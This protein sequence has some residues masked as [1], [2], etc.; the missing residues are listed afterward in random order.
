[1]PHT[2]LTFLPFHSFL[3]N[4]FGSL[5]GFVFNNVCLCFLCSNSFLCFLFRYIF[6]DRSFWFIFGLDRF[7]LF[8]SCMYTTFSFSLR[9]IFLGRNL[10]SFRLFDNYYFCFFSGCRSAS[11]WFFFRNFFLD[12]GCG[13]TSLLLFDDIK[14]YRFTPAWFSFWKFLFDD[15]FTFRRTFIDFY[16]F[17]VFSGGLFRL[18]GNFRR[19][20]F[21]N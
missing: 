5:L 1:M 15:R 13:F 21:F 9:Y 16:N 19:G 4:L 2:F 12:R 3:C 6:F 11:L 14:L 10:R 18:F 7:S 8:Y 17:S 20:R